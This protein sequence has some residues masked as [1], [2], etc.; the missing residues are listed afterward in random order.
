MNGLQVVF[1]SA[2]MVLAT[3]SNAWAYLDPGTGSFAVQ[4]LI[5]LIASMAVAIRLFWQNI[6][7]RLR[8]GP[9]GPNDQG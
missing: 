8:R 3:T 6:L 9:K 1:L 4:A 7:A 5:G 2:M